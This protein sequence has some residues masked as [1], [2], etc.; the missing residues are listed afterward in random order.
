MIK[1][2]ISS[3]TLKT[4]MLKTLVTIIKKQKPQ[5]DVGPIICVSSTN[6][7]KTQV[8]WAIIIGQRVRR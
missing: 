8:M 6:E 2:H 7:R 3:A 4:P 5:S 1:L